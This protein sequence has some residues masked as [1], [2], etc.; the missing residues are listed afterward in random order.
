MND[1]LPEDDDSYLYDI[2]GCDENSTVSST[3]SKDLKLFVV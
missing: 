3:C 1:R 2:L